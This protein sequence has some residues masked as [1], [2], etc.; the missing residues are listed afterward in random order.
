ML[1]EAYMDKKYLFYATFDY[2]C[3]GYEK[4]SSY[5]LVSS[6][7]GSIDASNKLKNALEKGL[8]R[9]G[10]TSFDPRKHEISSRNIL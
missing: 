5:F 4:G 3:Q 1:G 10:D 2:Y 7:Y 6:Q 9:M 8:T